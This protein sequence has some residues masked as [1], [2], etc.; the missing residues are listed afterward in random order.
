M[1]LKEKLIIVAI[2]LLLA[3]GLTLGPAEA[4]EPPP[5]A[6]TEA[7]RVLLI[8]ESILIGRDMDTIPY[9]IWMQSTY[10]D[11]PPVSNMVI[12][13]KAATC[14][15]LWNS[16]IELNPETDL[17]TIDDLR[18]SAWRAYYSTVEYVEQAGG[19]VSRID[20]FLIPTLIQ[21]GA[22]Q[23]TQGGIAEC[24]ILDGAIFEDMQMNGVT[25][26]PPEGEEL[27]E[28]KPKSGGIAS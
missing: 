18:V 26:V 5:E 4:Q 17:F 1:T 19:E 11:G 6:I 13:M 3:F 27:P 22:G 16:L 25:P 8:E 12:A 9:L 28:V 14:Y 21:T 10:N 15:I 2:I 23:F 7:E 24:T 20:S